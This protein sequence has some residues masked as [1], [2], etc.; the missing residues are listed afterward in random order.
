MS[1]EETTEEKTEAIY[2]P[3]VDTHTNSRREPADAP[4]PLNYPPYKS[5]SLRHPKQPLIYL[6]QTITEIT[7]PALGEARSIAPQ[8][9]DLTTQHEGETIGE[10]ITVSG[11][12]FD[13]DGK[14]LS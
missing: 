5:T 12:G 11:R 8:D 1:T 14:T 7:G 2:L 4:P 9:A 3:V 13:N 6:P 10:R